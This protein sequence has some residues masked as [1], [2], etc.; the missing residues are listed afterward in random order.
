[1]INHPRCVFLTAG[2]RKCCLAQ[3][4]SVI[5]YASMQLTDS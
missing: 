2:M 3:Y 4:G 1:M 5:A